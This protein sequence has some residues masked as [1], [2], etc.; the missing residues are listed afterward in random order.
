M[1][2]ATKGCYCG[3]LKEI[4]KTRLLNDYHRS[5][6]DSRQKINE[7]CRSEA[8]LSSVLL[9]TDFVPVNPVHRRKSL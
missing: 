9:I 2:P 5:I 7:L 3:E 1:S 8:R 6:S 4:K